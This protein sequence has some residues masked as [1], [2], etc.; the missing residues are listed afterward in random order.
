[1]RFKSTFLV[2]LFCLFTINAFSQGAKSVVESE[3]K[4]YLATLA[5][6][7]FKRAVDYL[8]EELLQYV[9]KEQM[10]E[11][12]DQTFNSPAFDYEFRNNR[13]LKVG[14]ISKIEQ[15]HYAKLRYSHTMVM[16]LL[17]QDGNETPKERTTKMNDIKALMDADFGAENVKINENA[18]EIFVEKDVIAISKDGKTD[19]RFLLVNKD[20][21][22]MIEQIFPA[23]FVKTL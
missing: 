16:K 23:E 22:K 10:L 13:I 4:T 3:F 15:K 20:Q 21:R 1:M 5:N 2:V 17:N 6:K 8:P 19:W 18:F 14:D 12:L 11:F 9:T 7:D